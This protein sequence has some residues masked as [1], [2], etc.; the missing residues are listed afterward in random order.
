MIGRVPWSDN[1]GLPQG[2]RRCKCGV[3]FLP[4]LTRRAELLI[5]LALFYNVCRGL[6]GIAVCPTEAR[7]YSNTG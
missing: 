1:P 4:P 7:M 6:T 3:P 5:F 2:E